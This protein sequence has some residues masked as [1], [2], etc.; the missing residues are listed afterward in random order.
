M[1]GEFDGQV[2]VITGGAGGMGAEVA[3]RLLAE[4]ARV[5]CV[6][7]AQPK[8]D[9][10]VGVPCDISDPS[11]VCQAGEYV[12]EQAGRVDHLVNAAGLVSTTR[13]VEAISDEEW[14]RLLGVN[15]DGAF[16]WTRAVIPA[17]KEQGRGKI[18]N[19]SSRAGRTLGNFAGAHYAAAKAAILGLTR[20]VAL[21]AAPHGVYV[22]AIAPGLVRT[23]MLSGS[24]ADERVEEFR[25]AT[26]LRRIGTPSD[27]ADLVLFLLSPKSDFITGA[28]V[29]I[30]GGDLIL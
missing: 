28:T 12:L 9:G 30:N 1:S 13:P 18:V 22:N 24:V 10:A 29:D 14:K 26:P 6:D 8:V 4:G 15:L 7:L 11:A 21:E 16:Y 25:L 19:V 3:A 23:P 20:Q 27:I 5:F 2:A 17:M